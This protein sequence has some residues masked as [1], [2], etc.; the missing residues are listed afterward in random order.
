LNMN[1]S[2]LPNKQFKVSKATKAQLTHNVN[3]N[4]MISPRQ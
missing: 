3:N 4:L 1:I 2:M